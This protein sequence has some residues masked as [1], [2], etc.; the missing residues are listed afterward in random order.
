MRGMS[1]TDNFLVKRNNTC[2]SY[3]TTG[4]KTACIIGNV[5]GLK[6]LFSLLIKLIKIY[7]CFINSPKPKMITFLYNLQR[8][9]SDK[10]SQFSH[11]RNCKQQK[12]DILGK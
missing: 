11:L 6:E 5:L 3:C 4:Y 7:S 8:L 9:E 10:S 12:V 1:S 2:L